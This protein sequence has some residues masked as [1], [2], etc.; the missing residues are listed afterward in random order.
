VV[1]Q[2]VEWFEG[3]DAITNYQTALLDWLEDLGYS[4]DRRPL[5]SHI[6]VARSPFLEKEWEEAFVPL[7]FQI[8]GLHL[9]E[10]IG[11]LRYI[12]LWQK[13]Q[14]PVFEEFQHTA[15][16]AFSLEGK[17]YHALYLH[18]AFALSFHYPPILQFLQE[19]RPQN[20]QE[21]VRHLNEMI[22]TCDGEIGCPFKAVSH[23]GQFSE[24]PPH[25]WEMIVDV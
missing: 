19:P 14:L 10:S 24:G 1:A 23:H 5:L 13:P 6:T 7:P 11:N 25:K 16:I 21:V 9:Y 3:F 18:G 15:D 4:V 8:T 2:H 22:A 20:I 17:D 12:S